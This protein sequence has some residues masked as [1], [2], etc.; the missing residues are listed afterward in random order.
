MVST[1]TTATPPWSGNEA[2][3]THVDGRKVCLMPFLLSPKAYAKLIFHCCKYPQRA[4]NGVLIGA[5]SK[6][7]NSVH[8]QDA[9]PLFHL[10][11]ALAPMLE[12]AVA[13]VTFCLGGILL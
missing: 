3:Q 6:K 11:L 7:D 12:I 10:D 5:V 1:W 2:I 9:V 13:Q 4:V 8:V